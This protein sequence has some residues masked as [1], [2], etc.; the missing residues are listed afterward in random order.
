MITIADVGLRPDHA[1][2]G[3]VRTLMAEYAALPHTVG[4]W[5]TMQHDLA[6]LP[7]PFVHPAGALLLATDGSRPLG[8]GAL[9]TLEPGIAEIK[10]LYVRPEARGRGVGAALLTALLSQAASL[11][12]AR[13]RLDT[14]PEL[15]EALALYRRFG[16]T[17]IPRYR[18]EQ[19]PDA[20][21]FERPAGA[22]S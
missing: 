15:T 1:E 5:L 19:L 16:F 17:P 11:G 3:A 8:C 4:R 22:P 12:F 18:P 20:L 2:V 10:R 6:R 21:C 9:C 7:E 13:V 14:A